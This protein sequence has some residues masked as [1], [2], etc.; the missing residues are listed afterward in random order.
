MQKPVSL[1]KRKPGS[2]GGAPEMSAEVR[3]SILEKLGMAIAGKRKEAINGRQTSGIEK[4]W[5]EDE[6]HYQGFD[7]ANR[8]E[9]QDVKSKPTEGGRSTVTAKSKGSTLFPNITG[10]YVDAAAAKVAD[11]LLPTDDRNFVIEPTPVPDILDEG[12]GWPELEQPAPPMPPAGAMPPVPQGLAAMAMPQGNP[13]Q[14]IMANP[15][16]KSADDQLAEIFAK[17]KA[18]RE[19][20]IAAAKLAQEE[21]DDNLT[22]CGYH[23]ELRKVIDDAARIGTGVVKGPVPMKRKARMWVKDPRTGERTLV[24]KIEVKPGSMRV[25][26]WNLFPDYPACGENIHDG[27]FIFERDHFSEKKLANLKGGEGPAAYIDEQIDAAISEGPGKRGETAPRGFQQDK[28]LGQSKVYVIWYYYGTITGEELVAAGC[29][30]DDETKQYDVLVTMVNDRVI[31]AARNPLDTGEFPYDM[32]PWK[33]RPGMPWGSGVARQGRTA[34]RI[35]TAATRNLMDN[36]GASSR[37]HKVMT[38]QVDQDGDPWTWRAGSETTDVRGAMQFF[39]QPS[40]QAE[41]MAII[42]LGERMMELHT[43]LPM[44]VLGMQGNIQETAAGR[45]LQNNNGSTVLR[46]IAR[47]FDGGI[48]EP[49]I[50]RYHAWHMQYNPR[51]EMKGDFQIK[52]R[53]SA[54]LVERD[55][56]NQQIP[57]VL[58]MALNPAYGLDPELSAEEYLKS[59]R[60][61]PKAFKLSDKKKQEMAAKPPPPVI[62]IEVAKIREAGADKRKQMDLQD[63]S[64][65]REQD[66]AES[67]LERQLQLRI[68]EIDAALAREDLSEEAR[69]ANDKHRV[70]LASLAMELR[71]QRE[72]SPGPQVREAPTE[73]AGRAP[74]GMA[75][76]Q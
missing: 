45:A 75:Y 23:P 43:G 40:L 70:A 5:E 31:K 1:P 33:S 39:V 11:M 35:V 64:A 12:E 71:Q 4:V 61:D 8:H 25:D 28:E 34:Q 53:G 30:C 54:A 62:P 67:E 22:E 52:A 21:I 66:K 7:D 42:Q 15:A 56:Q 29:K 20:A 26:L 57:T 58:Q 36:A 63:R 68:E 14:Q 76:P 19:K 51:D 73:P 46:R 48:T 74:N 37:P 38:D 2:G 6:A 60:F 27:S 17:L 9:F 47:N 69:Q 16:V 59:Q 65:E 41:L 10:P 18:T 13:A 32:L 49:Q 50:K 44:I 55:L 72:L 3:Q 24:Q